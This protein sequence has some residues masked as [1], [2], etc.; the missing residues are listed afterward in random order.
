MNTALLHNGEII[1]AK[2]YDE[3]TNGSRIYC[4]DKNCRAPLIHVVKTQNKSEHFKTTGKGESKHKQKCGFY[5]PLDLLESVAKVKEYQEDLGDNMNET[6]IRLNMN[7][8]DPDHES[9]AV[10]RGK[11]DKKDDSTKIKVKQDNDTPASISSV[12]S[13]VKLIT[14][15]EPDILASILVNVGGGYKIPISELVVKHIDAHK[16]L[17][18]DRV[19]DVGYFVYGKVANMIKRDKVQ[20]INFDEE[21]GVAFTIVLFQKYWHEF[22]YSNEELVGKHVMVYGHLRKNEYQG[23]RETEMIIKSD[24]Y[25]EVLKIKKLKSQLEESNEEE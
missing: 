23:K 2:E 5:E 6:L 7:R 18:E 21:Q 16:M 20:Y 17:W 12:K 15:Y 4:I 19:F 8:I 9:K 13:V 14:E 3:S 25:V 1:T 22:N 24:K 11:K 10:E